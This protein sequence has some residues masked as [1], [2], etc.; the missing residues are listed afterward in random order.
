MCVFANITNRASFG[1]CWYL[2]GCKTYAGRS[3]SPVPLG[4]ARRPNNTV[5][6]V[7]YYRAANYTVLQLKDAYA[8]DLRS[9]CCNTARRHVKTIA[10][11]AT[12][13]FPVKSNHG[14]GGCLSHVVSR[15]FTMHTQSNTRCLTSIGY[16]CPMTNFV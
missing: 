3:I 2:Q 13:R 7:V 11:Q 5:L 16:A 12:E 15:I 1:V 10:Q 8:A 6:L 14:S 4:K 9:V